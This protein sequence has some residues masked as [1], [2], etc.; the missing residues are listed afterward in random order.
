MEVS[1]FVKHYSAQNTQQ[2]QQHLLVRYNHRYNICIPWQVEVFTLSTGASRSPYGNLP[3]KPIQFGYRQAVNGFYY[4]LATDTSTIDGELESYNMIISFDITSEEFREIDLPDNLVYNR[5]MCNLS[6]SN[7]RES[8]VVLECDENEGVYVVWIVEDSVPE[9]FTKLFT[10]DVPGATVLRVLEFRKRGEPVI[11][12][13]EAHNDP[14]D[15]SSSLVVYEPN[16]KH[17]SNLDFSGTGSFYVN[18][19]KETLLLLDQP[20]FTVFDKGKRYIAKKRS[21]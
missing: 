2:Q 13:E 17:V 11:E 9:S 16:S 8:L 18:A 21:L 20:D 7:I 1:H 19:Y 12:I 15:D 3:R 4:W 10:I 5:S 14:F 6:I